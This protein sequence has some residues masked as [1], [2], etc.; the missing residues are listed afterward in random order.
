LLGLLVGVRH[1]FEPDHLTAVST[2]VTEARDGRRGALLGAIWGLGHTT[3][4][5]VVAMV[6]LIA[7]ARLPAHVAAA[8][9]LAVAAMLVLLGARVIA[10]AI[11]SPGDEPAP[12]PLRGLFAHAHPGAAS[13]VHIAGRIVVWRPLVVGLIHGLAGSG[14]LTALALAELPSTLLRILYITL[15]GLGSVAGMAIASGIA[16]VSLQAT[17]RHHKTRRTLSAATG[18]VS[19]TAGLLWSIPMV[20]VLFA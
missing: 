10:L 16:G 12:P 18:A 2:L 9:E 4:L 5:V 3:S 6:L 20:H 13:H 11:R 7:G 17:A 14:A 1:A 19:I 8:F 15:F